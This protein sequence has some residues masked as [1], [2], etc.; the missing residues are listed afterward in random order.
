MRAKI[1]EIPDGLYRGKGFVDSD[2]VIDNLYASNEGSQAG[3]RII[4]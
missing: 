4:F 1:K 2:G 3:H